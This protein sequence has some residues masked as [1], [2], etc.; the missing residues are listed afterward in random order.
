MQERVTQCGGQMTIN[1]T[2]GAGTRI[3]F[4]IPIGDLTSE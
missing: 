3:T 4:T 2:P 1:S